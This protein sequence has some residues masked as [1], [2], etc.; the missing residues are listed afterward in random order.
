[1]S[2]TSNTETVINRKGT[3]S[4]KWD[5]VDSLFSG[6]DLWPMWVADMDWATPVQVQN[7]LLTRIQHPV[8]GYTYAS[9]SLFKSIIEWMNKKH[10]WTIAKEHILFSPGVVPSLAAA[11]LAFTDIGDQVMIQTPV[12]GPF[13]NVIKQND[14]TVVTNKLLLNNGQFKIDFEDF[15]TKL[16]DG[17]KLFI[18]CSPHNPGGTVWHKE[19]LQKMISL[20]EHYQVP[21]ISDEIH[22]DLALFN[23]VHTPAGTISK[24]IVTL[25]APSKT[26]NIAG[27]NGSLIISE[28][29]TYLR[30]M[31]HQFLKQGIGGINVLAYTAM[32]AAYT[33]GMDWLKETVTKIEENIEILSDYIAKHLPKIK[34]MI[35]EASFLVWIDLRAMGLSEVEITERLI[36]KGKLAL[37][38]GTKYGQDGQGFV[39]MNIGC[40]KETMYEGL[41]RLNEAF[42]DLQ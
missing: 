28:N 33:H 5:N 41:R 26:F 19:D 35:P 34:I 29:A 16:R 20:C 24:E 39:R 40:S 4:Y 9:E 25:M 7:A 3:A 22:A 6:S 10:K 38:P 32:E 11:V 18:L 37:E 42:S 13:Y 17:V 21:I 36:N 15:E 30:K 27:L 14:R 12:Y 23:H 2:T 31:E 8:F 1:M